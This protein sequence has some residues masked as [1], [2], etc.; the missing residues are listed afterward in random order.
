M[1]SRRR[2]ADRKTWCRTTCL[3]TD[4]WA[5]ERTG[6]FWKSRIVNSASASQQWSS[7]RNLGNTS[8]RRNWFYYAPIGTTQ[9]LG[10]TSVQTVLLCTNRNNAIHETTNMASG[11]WSLL[12][13]FRSLVY[14][15]RSLVLGMCSSSVASLKCL[16][17]ILTEV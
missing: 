12:F 4:V 14:G 15:I 3:I 6:S 7:S 8:F 11:L 13:G 5:I 10:L 9:S 17:S 16:V 2:D 1:L